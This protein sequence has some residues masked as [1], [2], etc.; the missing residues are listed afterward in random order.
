MRS[1][2][3][4]REPRDGAVL[5]A[6]EQSYHFG[7]SSMDARGSFVAANAMV[8]ALVCMVH[9]GVGGEQQPRALRVTSLTCTKQAK[10]EV[11][12]SFDAVDEAH[13]LGLVAATER[14]DHRVGRHEAASRV[15][16]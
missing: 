11:G 6:R 15:H 7:N 8:D 1:S 13:G 10:A 14:V 9:G 3:R 12:R 4:A 16:G 2:R 5:G